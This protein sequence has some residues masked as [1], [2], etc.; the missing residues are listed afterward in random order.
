MEKFFQY[1]ILHTEKNPRP[2]Q[3]LSYHAEVYEKFLSDK[4]S[5]GPKSLTF[6]DSSGIVHLV[7]LSKTFNFSMIGELGPN[8][9]VLCS[10]NITTHRFIIRFKRR[11]NASTFY[12]FIKND[13]NDQIPCRIDWV[14]PEVERDILREITFAQY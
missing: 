11:E 2:L 1:Q 12:E 7:L 3:L 14:T 6:A 9:F 10:E 5:L 8:V 4:W 13:L